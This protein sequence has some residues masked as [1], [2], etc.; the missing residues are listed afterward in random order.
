VQTR[1]LIPCRRRELE[2]E[3]LAC[4]VFDD[5]VYLEGRSVGC[6]VCAEGAQAMGTTMMALRAVVHALRAFKHYLVGG[7][8]QRP[9]GC[10]SNFDLLA[11]NQEIW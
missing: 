5:R 4:P 8:A 3:T 10:G 2:R 6:I 11:N 1:R 9:A 7:G